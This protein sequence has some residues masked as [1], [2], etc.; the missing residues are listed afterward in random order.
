[1]AFGR[2]TIALLGLFSILRP[3][4]SDATGTAEPVVGQSVDITIVPPPGP[5]RVVVVLRDLRGYIWFGTSNGLYKYD[6]VESRLIPFPRTNP[7]ASRLITALIQLNDHVLLFGTRD[8]LWQ[9]DPATEEVVPINAGGFFAGQNITAI[10]GD[11]RGRAWIGVAKIGLIRYAGDGERA[12][13][14]GFAGTSD[15]SDISRLLVAR[16]GRIWIGTHCGLW[17]FDHASNRSTR[18]PSVTRST[19]S[20]NP[21]DISALDEGSDGTIWV[22]THEGLDSVDR[23]SGVVRSVSTAPGAT[24]GIAVIAHDPSGRL[25]AGGAGCGLSAFAFGRLFP[26]GTAS[27]G[28]PLITDPNI[29]A[30][31]VDPTSTAR[32]VALWIG[33]RDGGI[34]RLRFSPGGFEN[35]SRHQNLPIGGPGAVIS[36]CEDHV[37]LLWIGLWG[38]GLNVLRW[39]G[40]R[41]ERVATYLHTPG[42]PESLPDNT[43]NTIVEDHAGTIW[44]GTHNGLAQFDRERK[45]FR[46]FRHVVSDTT[47]IAGN[48]INTVYAD[49]RL[50]LWVCTDSG[51]SVARAGMPGRFDSSP[52]GTFSVRTHNVVRHTLEVSDI[53]EDRR[54]TLWAATYGT[55]L[56]RVDDDGV[57]HPVISVDDSSHAQDFW[58]YSIAVDQSG[59]LYVNTE[60]GILSFIPASGTYTRIPAEQLQQ[61]HVF[62]LTVDAL[63]RLWIS[64]SAGLFRYDSATGDYR[65]FGEHDGL[66]AREFFTGF[67]PLANGKIIVGALDG[68]VAFRVDSV[69]LA[70]SPPSVVITGCSVVGQ[71]L[72]TS[73]LVH[74]P[75]VLPYH[76]NSLSFSFAALDYA[77]PASN[78]YAYRMLGLDS[79]WVDAA[80]RTYATYANIEPGTYTFEVRGGSSTSD[81]NTTTA[82]VTIVI[83]PPFWQTWWFQGTMVLVAAGGVYAAYRYR[84]RRL[85]EM[86]RLRLRIADDLHD[87]VGSNLSAIAIMSRNLQRDPHLH[88]AAAGKVEQ[89]YTTAVATSE[90]LKDIVW[91]IRPDRDGLHELFLRMK[92]TAGNL[93]GGTTLHVVLPDQIP[94]LQISIAFRRNVFLS[95]K[96]ILAN[97][98]KHARADSVE[99]LIA[100]RGDEFSMRVSDDGIGF[101]GNGEFAGNGLRSLQSRATAV[102]G[103]CQIESASGNGTVVTFTARFS[104]KPVG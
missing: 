47:S 46:T 12:E 78:V 82:M 84:V 89:I 87:D 62:G 96:E 6:G 14:Y 39:T 99:I 75:I 97:I 76:H 50:R 31:Y 77:D 16:S 59:T 95:F 45:G 3:G 72:P 98:A 34:R 79:A 10:A 40:E 100:L 15:P 69:G 8:G 94:A 55:G 52:R 37:G 93:L 23:N 83:E 13:F 68:F 71:L 11:G 61:A 20:V 30:A 49:S 70:S 4:L 54:G 58:A 28:R 104:T 9:C 65:R 17:L 7:H 73:E 74:S 91:F 51:L 60:G 64:T 29:I 102:G 35:F 38:G 5:G 44:V 86:E 63:G 27:D 2:Y 36:L 90:G 88:G 85:L 80:H 18:F 42:N 32:D 81:W 66:A 33:T 43:V 53:Q 26:V 103:T 21:D 92:E 22:G 25:W 57:M 56:N 67:F 24:G 101:D 19:P 41:Y 48:V 1:M